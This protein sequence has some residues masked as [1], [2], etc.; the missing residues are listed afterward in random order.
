[1]LISVNNLTAC[2]QI[3]CHHNNNAYGPTRI[4]ANSATLIDF[5]CKNNLES[6]S[7][8][9]LEDISDHLPN[10]LLLYQ[11]SILLVL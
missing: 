6:K 3:P 8:S 7:D 5:P 2:Y 4:T 11:C 10:Y 1:M 9:F